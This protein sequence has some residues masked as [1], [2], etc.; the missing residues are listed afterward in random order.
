MEKKIICLFLL[1]VVSSYGFA[2]INFERGK[3]DYKS[4]EVKYQTISYYSDK[5][6]DVLIHD[7]LGKVSEI[8]SGLV[9]KIILDDGRKFVSKVFRTGNDSLIFIF[10]C[11]IESPGISLYSREEMVN[12]HYFVSKNDVLYK[13]ENNEKIL[14]NEDGAFKSY[15]SKY[16][17]T[18]KA[19][20]AD[21]PEMAARLD[22]IKLT[23]NDIIDVITK[24]NRGN[25]T[26][27]WKSGIKSKKQPSWVL[28][29]QYSNYGSYYYGEATVDN[30]YGILTGL[31]YYF[32][33]GCRHSL[34]FTMD[35]SVYKLESTASGY[36]DYIEELKTFSLGCRYQYD[37]VKTIYY[38]FYFLLHIGD[39]TYYSEYDYGRLTG[40]NGIFPVIRISPGIGAEAKPFPRL[41]FYA[42]LNNVLRLDVIPR[43][44][45]LG[46]KFDLSKSTGK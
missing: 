35:Y 30:S 4:G 37:F 28:F 44:F 29:G 21:Q 17:G 40:E 10:Q 9:D 3:V 34:R 2:Q 13:L 41:G 12:L 22:N 39:I 7:S 33:R 46:V 26:Y 18:L 6:T 38:N 25:L 19:L 36:F 23:E 8:S 16:I 32:F 43:S 42:E 24:Y 5:P 27:F 45:S 31:Q 11:I 14:R 20:M 15:D 1:L